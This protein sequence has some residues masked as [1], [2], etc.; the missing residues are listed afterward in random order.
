[1]GYECGA[2]TPSASIRPIARCSFVSHTVPYFANW[3]VSNL[4]HVLCSRFH[5]CR[6]VLGYCD[7]EFNVNVVGNTVFLVTS[8]PPFFY[9]SLKASLCF[10]ESLG[11]QFFRAP[12]SER[13]F[14]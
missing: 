2:I 14:D 11:S 12:Q 6:L 4:D 7:I 5:S 10:R 13:C 1:M 8:V 9:L 3:T